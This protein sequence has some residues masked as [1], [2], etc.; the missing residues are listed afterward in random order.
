[1]LSIIANNK[2]YKEDVTKWQDFPEPIDRMEYKIS[3]TKYIVMEGFDSYL[4]IKEMYKGVNCSV[5][6]T[7][8]IFLFGRTLGK[9]A[10]VEIDIKKGTIENYIVPQ[11]K[12]YDGRL[13]AESF[14]KKGLGGVS[15]ISVK[16]V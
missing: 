10:V 1:M 11:G 2:V 7:S 3:P 4:R 5:G 6:G 13:Q 9:T 16:D 12:E 15:K 8:K 14:W